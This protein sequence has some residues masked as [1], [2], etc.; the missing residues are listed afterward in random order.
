[1]KTLVLFHK[2]TLLISLR[3]IS[4]KRERNWQKSIFYHRINDDVVECVKKSAIDVELLKD[5][6]FEQEKK[7]PNVNS[8][9]EFLSGKSCCFIDFLAFVFARLVRLFKFFFLQKTLGKFRSKHP[10][11]ILHTCFMFLLCFIEIHSS[12][13]MKL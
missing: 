10:Q 6:T 5:E 3:Q 13:P 7:N 11:Q 12:F 1:M 9:G 4:L 8:S 2:S